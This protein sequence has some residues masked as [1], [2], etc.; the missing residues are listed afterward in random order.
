MPKSSKPTTPELS[1][2]QLFDNWQ[3]SLWEE[4]VRHLCKEYKLDN[5]LLELEK[6]ERVTEFSAVANYLGPKGE[7]RGRESGFVSAIRRADLLH[8]RNEAEAI[9]KRE[10]WEGVNL[11]KDLC[12]ACISYATAG[13]LRMICG[14]T[15]GCSALAECLRKQP[16]RREKIEITRNYYINIKTLIFNIYSSEA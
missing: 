7:F 13:T 2:Q 3:T 10:N 15:A 11:A 6:R 14:F 5:Y 9:L 12:L 8:C 1:I 16:G 4:A